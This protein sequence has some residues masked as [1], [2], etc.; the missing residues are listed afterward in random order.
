MRLFFRCLICLLREFGLGEFLVELINSASRIYKL[1]LT[2][3]ER[4][5]LV[6]YFKFNQGVLVSI[7]PHDRILGRSARARQEC[8]VTRKILEY[9]EAIIIRMNILFHTIPFNEAQR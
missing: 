5:R 4:V 8:L 2:C 3:K 1:H 7:F 9:Y 6:R